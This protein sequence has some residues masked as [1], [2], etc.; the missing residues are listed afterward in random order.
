[1]GYSMAVGSLVHS[2]QVFHSTVQWHCLRQQT[3]MI[4]YPIEAILKYKNE[5]H[6]KL[7]FFNIYSLILPIFMAEKWLLLCSY[8]LYFEFKMFALWT[9]SKFFIMQ[10]IE[11]AIKTTT[12]L[13][14]LL[15]L[16]ADATMRLE[17]FSLLLWPELY[18]VSQTNND[19]CKPQNVS[20]SCSCSCDFV[21]GYKR[22]S[23]Y[24]N[25]KPGPNGVA[26]TR[27]LKTLV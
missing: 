24:V 9:T 1:M 14:I 3:E 5:E 11:I 10:T 27:K 17:G 7:L 15:H 12:L 16:N 20:A 21:D 23:S 26:R 8:R 18:P 13:F 22:Y 2:L 4:I 19:R 6:R 25:L